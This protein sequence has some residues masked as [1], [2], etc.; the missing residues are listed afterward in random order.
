M[1]SAD[2]AANKQRRAQ[3]RLIRIAAGVVA[4]ACAAPATTRTQA[5]IDPFSHGIEK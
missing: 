2:G 4:C 3:H 5:T 1:A